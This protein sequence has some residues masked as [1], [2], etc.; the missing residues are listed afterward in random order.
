M[1][2]ELSAT[3][4][5]FDA[6]WLLLVCC[7]CDLAC[8]QDCRGDNVVQALKVAVTSSNAFFRGLQECGVF[9]EEPIRS[10]IVAS[11]RLMCDAPLHSVMCLFNRFSLTRCIFHANCF[12]FLF[13]EAYGYLAAATF[14]ERLKLFRLRPKLH[15]VQHLVLMLEAGE[16]ALSILSH[17]AW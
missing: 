5:F 16:S 2:A 11:G 3:A 6:A 8:T 13:Q 9:I 7:H 10:S 12:L 15:F 17:L 14:R 4:C 1:A